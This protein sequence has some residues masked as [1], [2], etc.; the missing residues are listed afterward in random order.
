MSKMNRFYF[1][2]LFLGLLFLFLSPILSVYLAVLSFLLLVFY[3]FRNRPFYFHSADGTGTF[4]ITALFLLPA[5]VVYIII[6][7][8]FFIIVIPEIASLF[9][10]MTGR[11]ILLMPGYFSVAYLLS[12]FVSIFIVKKFTVSASKELPIR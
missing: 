8:I 11:E 10:S 4:A 3:L 12:V 5:Y 1:I 9:V 7:F 2:F 6:F